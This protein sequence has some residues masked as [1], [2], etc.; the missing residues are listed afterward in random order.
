VAENQSDLMIEGISL[1]HNFMA[2]S[3]RVQM[4]QETIDELTHLSEIYKCTYN[5]NPSFSKLLAKVGSK[6]LSIQSTKLNRQ[7]YQTPLILINIDSPYN[8]TGIVAKI[9]ER[10]NLC[11]GEVI[12]SETKLKTE[13][14]GNLK[15]YLSMPEE[16]RTDFLIKLINA[17]NINFYDLNEFNNSDSKMLDAYHLLLEL[18]KVLEIKGDILEGIKELKVLINISLIFGFK[19]I[20]SFRNNQVTDITREIAKQGILISSVQL[21]HNYDQQESIIEFILELKFE[22]FNENE[23]NEI[24]AINNI[25]T[26][27]TCQ[28][29]KGIIKSVQYLSLEKDVVDKLF[30]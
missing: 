13:N 20:A 12:I 10:V 6:E 1:Y 19:I 17:I 15:F 23:F 5:G 28:E 8:I 25:H 24:K 2:E 14:L 16:W 7:E 3:I 18:K 29:N 9:I 30:P 26:F 21:S 11:H 27:L 4:S 22:H